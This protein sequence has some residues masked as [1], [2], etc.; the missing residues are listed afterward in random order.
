M[1]HD[2]IAQANVVVWT[3]R[4]TGVASHNRAVVVPIPH[5]AST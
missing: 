5:G 4:E 2:A 1:I 3:A